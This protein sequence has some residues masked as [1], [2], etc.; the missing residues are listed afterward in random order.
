M[1]LLDTNIC[2]YIINAKPAAVMQRF[3]QYQ[4]GEIGVCSVVTAELAYGVA[5][6][7][8]SRNRQALE[9][10]LAPLTILP[11]DETAVWAYGELSWSAKAQRSV[12][13]TRLLQPTL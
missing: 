6:S 2:I 8:S 12:H 1:I 11:F 4:I 9:M 3:R 13:S 10:F 7:G 5:K